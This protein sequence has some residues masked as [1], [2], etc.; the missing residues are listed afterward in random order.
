M[1]K[2]EFIPPAFI[3][4]SNHETTKINQ[5]EFKSPNEILKNLQ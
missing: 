4:A 5:K 2:A 1:A 3:D